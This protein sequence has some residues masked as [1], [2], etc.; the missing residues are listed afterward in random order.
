MFFELKTILSVLPFLDCHFDFFVKL[1]VL[2]VLK[3]EIVY[4]EV[5]EVFY[6][7]VHLEYRRRVLRIFQYF[8]DNRDMAV[9][10]VRVAYYVYEFTHF[11]VAHLRKH[12][13]KHCVLHHVPVIGGEGVLTA[14]VEYAVEFVAGD[15][16]SH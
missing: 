9:I 13:Q 15:V 2:I 4:G 3:L 10:D 11:E 16:E 6:I 14:L 5:V 12:M 7:L 1:C 8:L